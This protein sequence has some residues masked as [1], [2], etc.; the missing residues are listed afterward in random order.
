MKNRIQTMCKFSLAI[1]LSF[2]LGSASAQQTSGDVTRE[3][4]V[5]PGTTTTGGSIRLVDNKGTVKYL[6]VKNGLTILSNTTNDV[7]TT[8]WQLG[9]DL[10]DSTDIDFN[11]NAFT[12][13]NVPVSVADAATAADADADGGGGI[14]FTVLVRNEATG[15]IEK[16]LA[17]DMIESGHESFV[18]ADGQIAYVLMGAPTLPSFEQVWVFRNGAKLIAGA[19]YTVAGSTV[20][21]VPGGVP[22]NDWAVNA[23]DVVEVQFVK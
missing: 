19:D 20:T 9:G 4:D 23:G 3:A 12:F 14:G 21:L 8:T 17:S 22:P 7:T 6:Q 2:A 15:A 16:V 1:A 11:G 18:A 5:V 13:Q 10:S